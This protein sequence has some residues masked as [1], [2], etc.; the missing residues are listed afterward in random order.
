MS[1]TFTPDP[2]SEYRIEKVRRRVVARLAGGATLEGDIFLQPWA[3][4]RTGPQD[5]AELLNEPEPF[6]PM[7]TAGDDMVMVAKDRV[8]QVQFEPD[9]A[10]TETGGAADVAVDVV[11]ADGSR[12]SGELR[13]EARTDRAR[14]LDFLNGDHQRFLTLRTSAAVCLVNRAQIAQVRHGH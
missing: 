9:P 12:V 8:T 4:Y 7:S 1:S 5:P 3:R 11:F 2:M 10:N 13:L 14:L 6:F